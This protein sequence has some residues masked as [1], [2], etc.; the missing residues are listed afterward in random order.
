VGDRVLLARMAD[1][2]ERALG[3]LYDR[4]AAVVYSLVV[5]IVGD[6]DEA[7]DVVEDVFWQLWRQAPRYEESRGAVSTWVFTVARS[8]AL[9]RRRALRRRCE[10]SAFEATSDSVGEPAAAPAVA[11]VAGAGPAADAERAERREIVAAALHELPTE[12]REAVELAYFAGL[13]QTE[14]AARTGQPLGTVKTRTRLAM[15]KLR[16]RLAPLRDREDDAG[17]GARPWPVR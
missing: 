3:A 11:E 8:R 6:R 12:Q 13:S 7:E 16:D 10:E 5:R 2:D 4:W 9:D 1:G 15:Q 14:I 17:G